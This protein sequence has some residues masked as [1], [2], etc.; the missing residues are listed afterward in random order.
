M[1]A[2]ARRGHRRQGYALLKRITVCLLLLSAGV[3]AE[4]IPW[5]TVEMLVFERADPSAEETEHWPAD[6]GFPDLLSAIELAETAPT[7]SAAANPGTPVSYLRLSADQL[8]LGKA[9]QKIDASKNYRLLL[10]L[11]WRQQGLDKGVSKPVHVQSRTYPLPPASR[12]GLSGDPLQQQLAGVPSVEGT[13][14]M[15][16]TRYLHFEAD[17]RYFRPSTESQA[18]GDFL[19][20]EVYLSERRIVPTHFR[21][22]ESRRMR[23]RELH[24][25]DHPLF[26]VLVQITPYELESQE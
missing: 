21:L 17:L 1:Y 19:D 3:Q 10:H 13:V 24:Y 16:R 7:G 9:R 5:Y 14:R 15:Y 8:A 6:P 22:T 12:R 4:D 23:S 25:L 20:E 26:G 18:S 11:A 2:D